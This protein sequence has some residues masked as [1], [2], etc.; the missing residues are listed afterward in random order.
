MW[1]PGLSRSKLIPYAVLRHQTLSKHQQRSLVTFSELRLHPSPPSHLFSFLCVIWETLKYSGAAENVK[2]QCK[3]L[4]S[5]SYFPPKQFL[6]SAVGMRLDNREQRAG[7]RKG[8][9]VSPAAV[10]QALPLPVTQRVS[11]TLG[12]GSR[13]EH[14]SNTGRRFS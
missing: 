4:Q 5:S 13:I 11:P 7:L 8:K 6:F 1:P 3:A 9:R 14:L 2:F 10:W 12:V